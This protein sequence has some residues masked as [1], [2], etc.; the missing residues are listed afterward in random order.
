MR[1]II[2]DEEKEAIASK[3]YDR[4]VIVVEKA[5]Q[6][7]V[8]VANIKSAK[9]Q[10]L[11]FKPR[12]ICSMVHDFLRARIDEEFANDKNVAY[13]EAGG[14]FHVIIENKIVVRF[15]KMSKR[16][17]ISYSTTIQ[18]EK[19]KYQRELDAFPDD[20]TFFYSGYIPDKSWTELKNVPLVCRDGDTVLWYK[21]MKQEVVQRSLFS[22]P[23]D[24]NKPNEENTNKRVRPKKDK[25]TDT[26]T[27][28]DN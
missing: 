16:F 17:G 19:Y 1:N 18:S 6:D 13:K 23:N 2:S 7:Y 25:D 11:N 4:L 14:I 8:D 12:S 21:D 20:V 10:N 5:F 9:I 15:K 27:G 26:K 3:Y 24:E 28:T 22:F